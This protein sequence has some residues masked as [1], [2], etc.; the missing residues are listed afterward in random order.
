[1][2][3][4]FLF[5][6]FSNEW[7]VVANSSR[8]Q[9]YVCP[10]SEFG[11]AFIVVVLFFFLLRY[12]HTL[13]GPMRW[14]LFSRKRS[15]IQIHDYVGMCYTMI[16]T[17]ICFVS[18]L[19]YIYVFHYAWLTCWCYFL[20]SVC[21]CAFASVFRLYFSLL[22]EQRPTTWKN[23]RHTFAS[24]M[25]WICAAFLLAKLSDRHERFVCCLG[26]C[27]DVMCIVCV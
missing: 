6:L 13:L 14:W 8:G 7:N 19:V 27:A 12:T 11:A 20:F 26:T 22:C 25:L 4:F 5:S 18:R 21:L 23:T 2:K 10:S 3:L 9:T 17:F 24:F 16:Q 1:M 15:K